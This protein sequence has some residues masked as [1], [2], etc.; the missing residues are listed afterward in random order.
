MKTS[1]TYIVLW[2]VAVAIATFMAMQL[3]SAA[4]VDGHYI[5]AGNDSFYH[6]R[7]IIDA[8]MG[9]RG[10]Y[11][12]DDM[13]HVPEGSWLNWPWAYDYLAAKALAL[14]LFLR[15]DMEPMA[16][17]AYV[18]V[19]WLVVNMGLLTL[20]ARKIALGPELTAVALLGFALMPLTQALHGVGIIDHHFIEL[21][22]VLATLWA[23]LNFFSTSRGPRDAIVLGV[24]LGIAPAFHNGLFILQ[25]PVLIGLFI[26]WIRGEMPEKRTLYLLSAALLGST[27]LV[28]LPSEPFRNLQFEFWTLSW[29]HLYIAVCSTIGILF[30]GLRGPDKLNGGILAG[31]CVVLVLPIA[32]KLLIGAAFLGGDLILLN[33]ILEVKSPF[34]RMREPGG[35]VWVTSYYSW[36]I[37]LAPV[38]I[39]IFARRAC[40][41]TDSANIFF[42][43]FVVF[44]VTLMM[45]QYR[46]NPFGAWALLI[47][48]LLLIQEAGEKSGVS[49]M[50]M[51][52]GSLL[53]VAIAFQPPLKNRLFAAY[54]PGLSV[55]YAATRSL[56]ASMGESCANE[57]GTALS[58]NDD[59]HY[60]RYHTDCSVLTNNFLLTPQHER[61]IVAADRLLQL[62]PEQFLRAA[63]NVDYIFVRMYE[64]FEP[65]PNG[66]QPTPIPA[67]VSRNA[68]L[69]VAL[70]FA[71]EL[72]PEYELID[73]VR[74]QDERD[75]AYSRVFRINR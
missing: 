57:G 9:T 29:F 33:E 4:F 18:P 69:F 10:F 35:L 37:L 59:G 53:A 63:P 31:L 66:M 75:F 47:A 15:P 36:L 34:A 40:L 28:L 27:L 2:I 14:A 6:A 3:T 38:L 12:F 26:H 70:T 39:V 67:L 8:A 64:I 41:R 52:A 72:P 54:P 24:I 42:S 32:A 50:A 20:I 58:Y 44:G 45:I 17:L 19:A 13:I 49:T 25:L 7:R 55:D 62:D 22:F 11:Q 46:L 5:P 30:L 68:P 60:I 43:V 23:G 56:F 61:L 65:G 21:T 48:A 51:T 71:D 1:T 73:E 74:V 16:F